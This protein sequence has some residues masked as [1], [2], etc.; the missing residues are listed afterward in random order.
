LTKKFYIKFKIVAETFQNK[1]GGNPKS[2]PIYIENFLTSILGTKI[3]SR[4]ISEKNYRGES[5][6]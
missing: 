1:V 2:P 5:N 4:K 6:G 3:L